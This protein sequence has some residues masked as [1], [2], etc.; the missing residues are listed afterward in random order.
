MGVGY[1]DLQKQKKRV[2]TNFLQKRTDAK[3]YLQALNAK[4]L[5]GGL[6]TFAFFKTV[7]IFQNNFQKHKRKIISRIGTK[8]IRQFTNPA[9]ARSHHETAQQG[10]QSPPL[11]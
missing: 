5:P 6:D 7:S 4:A 9:K 1:W 8:G 10:W 11:G 2:F 3:D